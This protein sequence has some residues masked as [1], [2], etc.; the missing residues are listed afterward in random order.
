MKKRYRLTESTLRAMVREAVE[1]A[2]SGGNDSVRAEVEAIVEKMG[3]HIE[4]WF[5]EHRFCDD[6]GFVGSIYNSEEEAEE[7]I[8]NG[9]EHQNAIDDVENAMTEEDWVDYLEHCGYNIQQAKDI[10]YSGAWGKLVEIIVGNEGPQFFLATYSGKV[11]SL[12]NG[13]VLYY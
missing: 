1:D 6:H 8:L 9:D 11:H 2:L 4:G 12:S 10:I 13:M 5:S 7:D 3:S